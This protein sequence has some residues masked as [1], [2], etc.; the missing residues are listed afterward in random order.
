MA[1]V[2]ADESAKTRDCCQAA[3]P[4]NV[5]LLVLWDRE[6]HFK[7]CACPKAE[8]HPFTPR[9]KHTST[10]CYRCQN[11]SNPGAKLNL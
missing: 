5:G 8:K 9:Q 6:S 11:L 10:L 1:D 2:D 4:K 7:C 3:S